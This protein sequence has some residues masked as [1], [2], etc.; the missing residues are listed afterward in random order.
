MTNSDHQRGWLSA[1]NLRAA[2][3][4]L[5]SMVMLGAAVVGAQPAWA[6][7]Y[8][9]LYSFKGGT[10]GA[11]P[12][13]GLLRDSGG[14]LY[15]TT[16]YGGT[17]G[18]NDGFGDLG[19]GTVFKLDTSGNETVLHSF[20][21][22]P[23]G[24]YPYAGLVR[25]SSGNLYGTT[26]S[27]GVGS[28]TGFGAGCG[29]AFKLDTSGNETVLHSFTGTPDGE[30][31]AAGLVRDSSGNLYGTTIQGGSNPGP[32]TSGTVFKID[33]GGNETVLHSF[34]GHPSDGASPFAELMLDSV[35][36]LYGTT[37]GHGISAFPG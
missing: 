30:Y 27:G 24:E 25:D 19:C 32:Y 1:T 29:T 14:N 33:A 11:N 4:V 34:T 15:G 17:G 13:G 35:G 8:S 28:C 18:C 3:T 22:T 16:I 2:R 6:Q 31:P 36:N 20:T 21:G 5:A 26:E 23:D 10:D 9:V 12:F 7:T 37:H